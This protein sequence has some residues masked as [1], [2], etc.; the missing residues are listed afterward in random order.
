MPTLTFKLA[1]IQADGFF[2]DQWLVIVG[3]GDGDPA[4][5]VSGGTVSTDRTTVSIN[6]PWRLGVVSAL[7]SSRQS[8]GFRAATDRLVP[9]ENGQVWSVDFR[10]SS[11]QLGAGQLPT[12]TSRTVTPMLVLGAVALVGIFLLRR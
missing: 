5:V 6:V 2:L 4:N 8:G 12:I 10:D 1:S 9:F 11:I 3:T 7:A